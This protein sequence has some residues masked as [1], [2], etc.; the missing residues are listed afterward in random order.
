MDY[1]TKDGRTIHLRPVGQ[2]YI[3]MIRAKHPLPEVPTYTIE[4]VAGDKETHPHSVIRD[5]KGKVLKSTLETPEDWAVW[6]AYEQGTRDA[7]SAQY[8]A[9]TEFLLY[10]AIAEE[11]PPVEEWGTDLALFG[12]TPP[13]PHTE[14]VQHKAFWVENELLPDQDDLSGILS[15]LYANAGIIAKDRVQE[16]ESFFRLTLARLTAAPS[17]N[18]PAS[19]PANPRT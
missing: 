9:I 3:D 5:D 1:T 13:D 2:R 15:Q 16:F 10:N 14:P 11:P 6:N 8:S 7:I 12:L 17:A 18:T 4:T 19:G